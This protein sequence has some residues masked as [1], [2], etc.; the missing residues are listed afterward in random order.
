MKS[1]LLRERF[2]P[3]VG[4][5]LTEACPGY[6]LGGRRGLAASMGL[7]LSL[8]LSCMALACGVHDSRS[9]PAS[10]PD[11]DPGNTPLPHITLPGQRPELTRPGQVVP[12]LYARS[13]LAN[14]LRSG[15]GHSVRI[16]LDD[17]SEPT[18]QAFFSDLERACRD[19]V[20]AELELDESDFGSI[21]CGAAAVAQA[22]VGVCRAQ[23][24]L[25]FAKP[26]PSGVLLDEGETV[27]FEPEGSEQPGAR[28]NVTSQVLSDRASW[29]MYA[30]AEQRA[31]IAHLSHALDPAACN[32]AG[33]AA[34]VTVLAA[35][36][37]RDTLPAL[38]QSTELAD[39]L[40]A[41]YLKQKA[42]ASQ[43]APDARA[44]LT[45]GLTGS[46]LERVKLF[47]AVPYG[48]F[49]PVE[50]EAITGSD[51]P[52][53][54]P[55]LYA[56]TDART[57][58][59]AVMLSAL[60][61]DLFTPEGDALR[62]DA[63]LHAWFESLRAQQPLVFGG[64][65]ADQ[66]DVALGQLRIDVSDLE[67]AA[68]GL[69]QSLR[70]SGTPLLR[71]PHVGSDARA[72]ES[73]GYLD[74]PGP[75]GYV[76]GLTEARVDAASEAEVPYAVRGLAHAREAAQRSAR[77]LLIQA[78]LPSRVRAAL[79]GVVDET[80]SVRGRATAC[81]ERTEA[82]V[83]LSVEVL[84]LPAQDAGENRRFELFA[85]EAD[86]QCAL[87]G[88][89][90]ERPCPS[91][92]RSVEQNRDA[93]S[94]RFV[95]QSSKTQAR[96]FYLT[97]Q[98]PGKNERR[99]LATF[100][101][102]SDFAESNKGCNSLPLDASLHSA[103]QA[104]H[105]ESVGALLPRTP[106]MPKGRLAYDLLPSMPVPPTWQRTLKLPD[107]AG[108]SI[109]L[110]V[111]QPLDATH[112]ALVRSVFAAC[113]NTTFTGSARSAT[114]CGDISTRRLESVECTLAALRTG[115]AI[116][117]F[118]LALNSSEARL[119]QA[120]W[121]YQLQQ[122]HLLE[123]AHLFEGLACDE[124]DPASEQIRAFEAR[125]WA[126]ADASAQALHAD[127]L[128]LRSTLEQRIA[129][130]W[131]D[132]PDEKKRAVS[133]VRALHDSRLAL[134]RLLVSVP[135][136]LYEAD[137]APSDELG[138]ALAHFPVVAHP[139]LVAEDALA[140]SL[141][142]RAG[143]HPLLP[144]LAIVNG[145][146][147]SARYRSEVFGSAMAARLRARLLEIDPGTYA[148]LPTASAAFLSAVGVSSTQLG[149]A[150]IRLVEL[151][152]ARGKSLLSLPNL[153]PAQVAGLEFSYPQA[154]P[155]Q[156]YAL[157]EGRGNSA[158]DAWPTHFAS[159]GAFHAL[160]FLERALQRRIEGAS[161]WTSAQRLSRQ[162][163]HERIAAMARHSGIALEVEAGA[164]HLSLVLDDAAGARSD[165]LDAFELWWTDAGLQCAL[166]GSIDGVTCR[167]EDFRFGAQRITREALGAGA[168]ERFAGF[169]FPA[170]VLWDPARTLEPL[171]G[172]V[173]VTERKAA[174]RHVVGAASLD[175]ASPIARRQEFPSSSGFL[176]YLSDALAYREPGE[177][178]SACRP[179]SICEQTACV[180]G[181]CLRTPLD[182]L[183]CA[184]EGQCS[185]GVCD[186]PGCGDGTRS[187]GND[188]PFEACDDGNLID[189][190]GC[191][192]SCSV[193]MRALEPAIEE[194][195]PSG[196]APALAVDGL[197]RSLAVYLADDLVGETVRVRAARFDAF[198]LQ[199]GSELSVAEDIP[200]GYQVQPTVAG[201]RDGGFVVVYASP[202][203]EDASGVVFR[204]VDAAGV[205]GPAQAVSDSLAAQA[206][207][208]V[209]GIEDGFAV[210][211]VERSG[212]SAVSR[213]RLARFG[214]D[215]RMYG[216]PV[217]V[218]AGGPAVMQA[219]PVL[220]SSFGQLLLLWSEASNG[221]ATPL[222]VRGYR[223]GAGLAAVDGASF[224]VAAGAS[225]EPSVSV[226]DSGEYLVAWT[227]RGVDANG[228]IRA[229]SVSRF[230]SPL[231]S[232]AVT[233]VASNAAEARPVIAAG[234]G[235]NYVLAYQHGAPF[236]VG[237]FVAPGADEET[238]LLAQ[239]ELA[240]SNLRDVSVVRT[241]QSAWVTWSRR[242]LGKRS[243][244]AMLVPF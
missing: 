157:S 38:E 213:V 243:L 112:T 50:S 224:E 103:L 230:G 237:A 59:V 133:M 25:G 109:E 81:L 194:G 76:V 22:H 48:A 19:E 138:G 84:D 225:T 119:S 137:T 65:G 5:G 54:Y 72:L 69:R 163:L 86:A 44:Q 189:G 33:L 231:Q 14:D 176:S 151:S 21:Q 193:E 118:R 87:S 8:L 41:A 130:R 98:Q 83:T 30:V 216:S 63:L 142:R 57:E 117:D 55:V 136:A 71:T 172:R 29:A 7:W 13:V 168:G 121:A 239:T 93:T 181:L 147:L 161:E 162:Q 228:D 179:Y 34:E 104:V 79:T 207:A 127:F 178:C 223:L 4:G 210:A 209:V 116:G 222:G 208:R 106:S 150:A 123:L 101:L 32:V 2:H 52:G 143:L 108:A 212:V 120:L 134:A 184:S 58:Q 128:S 107:R 175:A 39:T 167:E 152:E 164:Q 170:P 191:S 217:E 113:D 199:Q 17:P 145:S 195:W 96:H 82:E 236:S 201:L 173:Y 67:R 36:T 186:K 232:A 28:W 124:V 94:A 149:N 35:E 169:E 53:R 15:I 115:T 10:D 234:A 148:A 203:V 62:G 102:D 166:H 51:A 165:P 229:R 139:A 75:S 158:V 129:E 46:V 110:D 91:A 122:E 185:A 78:E 226:K 114:L 221:G 132:E 188:V 180:A 43:D 125:L 88:S 68:D 177:G 241:P 95:V 74:L 196:P 135:L 27:S 12:L 227:F 244:F 131:R 204:L 100:F 206:D 60:R 70:V 45:R 37:L 97:E 219:E 23:A 159:H 214:A 105:T 89:L 187:D 40:L 197:G 140:E 205:V 42:E 242:A 6:V 18:F 73:L 64:L 56:P 171:R 238:V 190:D 1:L 77:A 99:V 3:C 20:A 16:P 26:T 66:A 211:W 182:G 141:L 183:A 155:A 233:L 80:G 198:G 61:T 146:F 218:E 202:F 192:S 111:S 90:L 220:A 235:E 153:L 49:V 31:L 24:A 85:G 160:A 200:R 9:D 92:P 144:D 47:A 156:L 174:Q 11:V 215:G 126:L 154:E 240:Q